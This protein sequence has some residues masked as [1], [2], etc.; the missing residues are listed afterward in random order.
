MGS[1][2][3]RQHQQHQQPTPPHTKYPP[4]TTLGRATLVHAVEVQQHHSSPLSSSR[5]NFSM[6]CSTISLPLAVPMSPV[7]PYLPFSSQHAID[8]PPQGACSDP[9]RRAL[10]RRH[11][12][13]PQ[14]G[15]PSALGCP[16]PFALPSSCIQPRNNGG[17]AARLAAASID[18]A[19]G[20]ESFGEKM[21]L[22]NKDMLTI[23]RSKEQSQSP[24]QYC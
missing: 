12:P 24:K 9:H 2:G 17:A 8:P 4:S 16:A 5:P 10:G 13:P 1:T 3:S 14:I 7:R 18:V 11:V 21:R 20:F 22:T 15:A 23:A 6:R 19:S